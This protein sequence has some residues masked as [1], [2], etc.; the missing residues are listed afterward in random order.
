MIR[1]NLIPVKAAKKQEMLRSQLAVFILALVVVSL[2][3]SGLYVSLTF[4]VKDERAL[5]AQKE[6]EINSLKKVIGE[7]SQFKKRQEE[8]RG[9]LEILNKLSEGKTGP[10]HLLDE[11]SRVIPDK[12]WINS[13]KESKGGI[14]LSGISLTEETVAQFMRDLE[15]SPYY[16]DVELKVVEQSRSKDSTTQKFE[17]TCK[18]ES[19]TKE[20]PKK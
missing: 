9:K 19:L 15:Q 14:V 16:S 18:A 2:A 5:V 4:K 13:F 11:L 1:I 3:C 6:A 7:V 20:S 8:L 12:M 10:V 17:I